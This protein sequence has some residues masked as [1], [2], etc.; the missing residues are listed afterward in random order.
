MA[1]FDEL[2]PNVEFQT[3]PLHIWWVRGKSSGAPPAELP[4]KDEEVYTRS[5]A[6]QMRRYMAGGLTE[7]QWLANCKA[8]DERH[9]PPKQEGPTISLLLAADSG[10]LRGLY[11]AAFEVEPE[12][13]GTPEPPLK[14]RAPLTAMVERGEYTPEDR[15]GSD[16]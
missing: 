12:W 15:G 9:L 10:S 1:R 16:A 14:K 5:H 8:L 4:V 7:K 2:P 13:K 6:A 3:V 11:F